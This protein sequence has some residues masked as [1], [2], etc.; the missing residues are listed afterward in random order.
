MTM[1]SEHQQ[2]FEEG[3]PTSKPERDPSA[4][5]EDLALGQLKKADLSAEDIEAIVRDSSV[6]KSRKVRFA[7]ATHLHTPRRIALRIVRELYTFDLMQFALRSGAPADL[8]RIADELMVG[9][10]PSITLGERISLARRCSNSVAAALL[11][12]K[13]ARVW[14]AA[15]ANP[16]LT[17]AGV[18]EALQRPNASAGFVQAVC[19]HTKWSVRPE[20]RMALLRSAHTPL[21]RAVEFARHISPALLRDILHNSR[22]PESIKEYLRKETAQGRSGRA[23]N[24]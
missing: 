4:L 6:M 22:L 14:Q 21:A 24:G 11:L 1:D 7:V 16:R 20:V 8:K 18:T 13:E 15:L 2:G 10:L 23:T 3:K 17:E 12:D 19:H 5:T 9:R